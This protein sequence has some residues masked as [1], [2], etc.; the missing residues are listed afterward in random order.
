MQVYPPGKER[1]DLGSP[2]RQQACAEGVAEFGAD[3]TV[4]VSLEP[5]AD[6]RHPGDDFRVVGRR[7]GRS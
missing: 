2:S 7:R 6:R 5:V 4:A 3:P 1:L